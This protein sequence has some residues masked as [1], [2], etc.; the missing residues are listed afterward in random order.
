MDSI[1]SG[2]ILSS[3]DSDHVCYALRYKSSH[4]TCCAE[5]ELFT[6]GLFPWRN[7]KKGSIDIKKILIYHQER[8]PII[9]K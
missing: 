1:L 8:L 3:G 9:A 7:L 4:T 5:I 2:Y 6:I